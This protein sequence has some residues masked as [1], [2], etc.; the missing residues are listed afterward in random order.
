MDVAN[1]TIDKTSVQKLRMTLMAYNKTLAEER[2][3]DEKAKSE[4][5]SDKRIGRKKGI[6]VEKIVNRLETTTYLIY[7]KTNV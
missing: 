6:I 5:K 3:N 2:E 4:K 7:S 1:Y